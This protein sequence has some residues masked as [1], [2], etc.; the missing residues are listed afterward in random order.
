MKSVNFIRPDKI[1]SSGFL[2]QNKN[3]LPGIVLLQEWWGVNNQIKKVAESLKNLGWQILVPDLYKGK[4]AIEANEAKHLMN[5]LNFVDAASQDV[6]G[7]VQYLK[8][9]GASKVA[10]TGFCM[11]GALTCLAAAHVQELD[12]AVIWYGY[13]SPELMEGKK[14]KIPLLGHFALHDEAFDI[15][16]V[17]ELEKKLNK[18]KSNF[19]FFRYDAKHAFANEEADSKNLPYLQYNEDAKKL[20]WTRTVTFL[21]KHLNQN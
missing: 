14:I 2:F 10:V 16:G 5:G 19:E 12:C 7:A 1:K 11:G 21:N 8:N 18:Q 9:N 13:P 6:R 3:D 17:D 15:S 4:V 20:A